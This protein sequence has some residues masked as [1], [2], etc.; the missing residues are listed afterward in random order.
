MLKPFWRYYGGKWRAAPRYPAPRFSTIVEPF[1]GA[2]GYSMRYPDRQIVLVEKYPTICEI[3]RYLIGVTPAEIRRIPEVEDIDDLPSWVPQGARDLI[4]FCMNDACV[5]PSRTLSAGRKKLASMN[6]KFEGWSE[7]KR[8]RVA[9]QVDR[10]K[11][12][13]IIEGD[14]AAAP[15]IEA[16]WFVD[17]P[18]DNK[19]GSYYVH[20][21]LDYD[22]L[23][24]WCLDRKGQVLVCENEGASWLPFV[25]FA[26]LKA[27]VNGSG[28][29]EVLW[30]R[31]TMR[32]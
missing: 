17:P 8:E 3:W 23:G 26:T 14:Y 21:S 1:S 31:D 2:A 19:A 28:S 27:G 4:G 15:D 5:S 20:S 18:Y 24:S 22:A 13:Q 12:W 29:R 10:I 11:H 16:T 7:A 9:S 30:D 6:R 32:G 25:P